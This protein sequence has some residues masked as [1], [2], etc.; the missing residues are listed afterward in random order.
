LQFVHPELVAERLRVGAT[1]YLGVGRRMV[2]RRVIL[3]A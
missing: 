2:A 1:L 3:L